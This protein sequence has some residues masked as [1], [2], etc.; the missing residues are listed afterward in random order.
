MSEYAVIGAGLMG[1]VIARDLVES[2]PEATVT[3][4]DINDSL[5]EE[6]VRFI[7]SDHLST[8]VLDIGDTAAAT[9]ALENHHVAIGALPHSMSYPAT[10][11]AL[12]ARVSYIDLV[13]EAPEPLIA[14][15]EQA[16]DAG[17]LII[18]GLG[19]AP[20]ISNIC[21][22][23]GIELL[24]ETHN[25]YIYVGGIP[26]KKEP[27]LYY[28]TVYL[29]ESVFNAY[30]RPA[31]IIKNGEPV[32]VEPLSG[33]EEI[34][35]P[36]PIGTL[37]AFFT[38]GLA[39]LPV[40]VGDKIKDSLFEKTL[41]YP[42]HV[43]CMRVLIECGLLDAGPVRVDGADVVPRDVLIKLLEDKLQLGPEGDILVMRVI[44]EGLKEGKEQRHVFELV[45]YFDAANQYTAMART[46]AFPAVLAARMMASNDLPERG[47]F[48]PEQ[49]FTGDRF[50]IMT[51][52]LA[53][54]GVTVEYLAEVS[55]PES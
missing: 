46:T 3:L 21:I 40:T 12:R 24:D 30:L 43:E 49:L 33:L 34:S 28:Q 11:A 55:C 53:K 17:C 37:E 38:D 7:G 26:V 48:F 9:A 51:D 20:G 23:R 22:A 19:V 10:V 47:V 54:K 5:L 39:S 29:L 27:P 18:P 14:L 52:E 44:V 32:T 13:G 2:E 41:R 45:D 16:V 35:F 31:T 15:H 36:E 50:E 1:R 25:G 4:F 8:R 42:G 6:A